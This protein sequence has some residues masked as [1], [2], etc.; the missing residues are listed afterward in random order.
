MYAALMTCFKEDLK[1]VG[2]YLIND[3]F[4]CIKFCCLCISY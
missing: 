2:S 3:V 1:H 4:W